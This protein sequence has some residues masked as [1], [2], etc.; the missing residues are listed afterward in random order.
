VSRRPVPLV[1]LPDRYAICRLAPDADWPAWA[2]GPL[3]SV[4]RTPEEVSVVCPADAVPAG[5]RVEGPW[6]TLRVAGTLEFAL[7]GILAGISGALAAAGV[8]CFALSTFDTDYLLV[9]ESDLGRAT[10]ALTSAGHVIA[11]AGTRNLR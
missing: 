6:R 11:D 8:S 5:T 2:G 10:E 3:V 4:T 7:T 1:V 9:R